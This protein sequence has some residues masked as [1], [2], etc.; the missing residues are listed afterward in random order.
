MLRSNQIEMGPTK[1]PRV[2]VGLGMGL[3][4][5]T[6]CLGMSGRTGQRL[7]GPRLLVTDKAL[8]GSDGWEHIGPMAMR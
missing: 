6:P 7:C 3:A 8:K 4:P 1:V 5:D 2:R